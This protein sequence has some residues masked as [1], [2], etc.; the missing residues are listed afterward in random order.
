MRVG[1]S[2][3][4]P[5]QPFAWASA[6]GSAP[7]SVD[8][9]GVQLRDLLEICALSRNP[10]LCFVAVGKNLLLSFLFSFN[11]D[12]FAGQIIIRVLLVGPILA[13]IKRRNLLETGH[14]VIFT[15]QSGR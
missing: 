3:G 6:P 11:S 1:S 9:R 7:S 13:R 2:C 8:A 12:F 5:T 15:N 10:V 14:F 4:L